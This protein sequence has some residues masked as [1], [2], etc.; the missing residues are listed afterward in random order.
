MSGPARDAGKE[1]DDMSA[2]VVWTVEDVTTGV[3]VVVSLDQAAAVAFAKAQPAKFTG[4]FM[5][6][7]SLLVGG[8]VY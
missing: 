1:D 6:H 7:R 4:H 5:V 3:D 2:K 8:R